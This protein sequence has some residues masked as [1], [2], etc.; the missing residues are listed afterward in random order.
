MVE[1]R[2]T[3][4]TVRMVLKACEAAN[5][6][7]DKLLKI[8]DISRQ[9]A[10]DPDGEVTFEQ[11]RSFWHTAYKMSADPYLAMRA[12]EQIEIG[13]YKC[14]DYLTIHA[15]TLGQSIENYCRYMLLVNTWIG[16]DIDKGK[17]NVTLRMRPSAGVI[18]PPSYEFVFSALTIRSRFLTDENWAPALVKFPFVT[19]PNPEIHRDFFNCEVQYEAPT[20]EYIVDIESWN[21]E[22]P[23]GDEHLLQVLDE[24]ARML[25]ANRP[26]PD[27]FIGKVKQEII[28]DLHGG[29]AT[30]DTIANRL[31]MSSRTLQRRLDEQGIAFA[32]LLDDIRTELAKNK[33]QGSDLSLAE[34]GF[35]LGFSEQSSFTRAFKRWTG[36]TPLEYRRLSSA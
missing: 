3:T 12:A 18:P 16:W 23:S 8:A 13:D 7:T 11:M 36:K 15:T 20:G 28:K 30:R 27:D 29:E 6:D 14:L 9:T 1:H 32:N 33:L 5:I 22:L 19:P 4:A 25:L 26:L 17:D 31:N 21:K 24:H 35:L 10:E 2:N 34:I